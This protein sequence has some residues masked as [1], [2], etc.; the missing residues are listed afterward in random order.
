MFELAAAGTGTDRDQGGAQLHYAGSV[1]ASWS[2]AER[3]RLA[4]LL[5]TAAIDTCAFTEIPP[6]A[7]APWVLG[8]ATRTRAGRLRHPSWHRLIPDLAPGDLT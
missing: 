2:Q 7:G 5:R 6:V 1:G 4:G 8:Y 3:T